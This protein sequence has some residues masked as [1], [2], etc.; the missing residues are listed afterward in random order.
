MRVRIIHQDM[1]LCFVHFSCA[2]YVSSKLI[3]FKDRGK[4]MPGDN[5]VACRTVS[6]VAKGLP[7]QLGASQEILE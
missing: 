2:Y 7:V 4:R 6:T 3:F 5:R 1:H